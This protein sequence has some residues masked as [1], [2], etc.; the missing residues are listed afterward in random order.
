MSEKPATILNLRTC[1][2]ADDLQKLNE[3]LANLQYEAGMYKSLYENSCATIDTLEANARIQAKLLA[4]TARER[5]A[6]H[7]LLKM[8][9]MY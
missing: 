8:T 4:D 2:P 6:A 9:R 3:H 7:K 5:D 1:L